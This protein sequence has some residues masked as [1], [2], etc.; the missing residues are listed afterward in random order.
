[1]KQRCYFSHQQRKFNPQLLPSPVDYYHRE[2]PK[3]IIKRAGWVNV[4]CCFHEDNA[5]SLSINLDFGGFHCFGC[6]EKGGDI[7]AFH[8]R[9]YHLSFVETVNRFG[10]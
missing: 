4:R 3:M 8:Q 1:M 5:P 9:R 6:G 7:I 2:F 10:A